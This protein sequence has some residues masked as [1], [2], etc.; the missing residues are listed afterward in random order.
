RIQRIHDIEA[1]GKKGFQF[2][3]AGADQR[4]GFEGVG[5]GGGAHGH[6]GGG[7]A[8]EA[9]DAIVGFA[10][11]FDASDVAQENLGAVGVDAQKNVF[12]LVGRFEASLGGDGGVEQL[13]GGGGV[14]AELAGGDL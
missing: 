6:A 1:G 9:R 5:A 12:E 14:A 2:V 7:L 13:A 3:D 10:A 4:D 11:Q 8:V